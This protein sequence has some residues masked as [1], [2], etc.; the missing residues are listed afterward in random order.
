MLLLLVLTWRLSAA[1]SFDVVVYGGT[2]GGVAAAVSAAR[3]GHSVA[4]L[5]YHNHLGGMSASGLGKSD[6]ET[7]EAI[8]GLFREF[9]ERMH[10]YY[11][12]RYGAGSSNAKL[13]REG[14]YYE[15]S[16]AGHMFDVMVAEQPRIQVLKRRLLV[17]AAR[18]GNRVTS[19]RVRNRDTSMP[20]DYSAQVFID[21]TYEGDLYASAGAAYRLGRESR[22]EF[23]EL[24][25]GV[26]YQDHETRTFLAGTTGQ[27]DK[28]I[29]AYTFRLCMTTN[30]ANSRVLD[31]PPPDYDRTR[32]LAYLDDWKAGRLAPP[33]VMKEGLG[34]YAPTFGTLVRA[35]SMA[36][37]P[38]GKLDINMNPRPLGFPFA[39][40][41]YDYPEADWDRRE[42]I[43]TTIRNVT[44]GL[45]YFL[46]ND[47]AVPPDHR[48]LARQFH[49]A[50]DEFTDNQNFPW[51]L[52]V[53]EARRLKGLYTLSEADVTAPENLGRTRVHADSIAAGEFPIDS[54][55][56]RR[57]EPGHDVALEG[58]LLML[59]RF[60]RPYQIPY[61]IM[62]PEQ[63]D[64]VIV[65][66]A[67]STTHVAYSTIRLEPTWMA[68]G[69]AAGVAA[70]LAI[71][72]KVQP[73]NVD[74]DR[75]QR[76]LLRQGQVITYFRDIDR[77][78]P[79]YAA[80]QYYGTKGLFPTYESRSRALLGN[81]WMGL[82]PRSS[83]ERITRG[84]FLRRAYERGR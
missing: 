42:Q 2:P 82:L 76:E 8:G 31:A 5:E 40:L 46:Q 26:V 51:Q 27:G 58:Y 60:T 21:A 79:A 20:E 9:V 3:M 18:Q 32:Y 14:Y 55:P 81:E 59:D 67:A 1:Q 66:V 56:T 7:K 53:R 24:H 52:Y 78:D 38:N 54:F 4:L 10:R 35:L 12:A 34:Y 28:R 83:N 50:K 75:L 57:R 36:D 23:N 63:V 68:L 72:A 45:I 11:V 29:Q 61:R 48:K 15:P 44:L 37:L 73:R 62:I 65:P 41:N 30:A 84:E 33:K 6:I 19:I 80:I 49:L 25:A 22:A 16:V 13:S 70:H 74:T 17:S 43:T 77:T 47:A 71:T 69:Q 64:G 39:E